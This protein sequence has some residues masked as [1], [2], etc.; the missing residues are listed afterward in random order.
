MLD[1]MGNRLKKDED[2]LYKIFS[3]DKGDIII[4]GNEDKNIS[5]KRIK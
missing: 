1:G 4:L 5:L 2:R 3:M